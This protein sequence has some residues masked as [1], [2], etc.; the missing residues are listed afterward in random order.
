MWSEGARSAMR[1]AAHP[2]D[3]ISTPVYCRRRPRYDDDRST[4]SSSRPVILQAS[5]L[6]AARAQMRWRAAT[7]RS[8]RTSAGI[9]MTIS[10]PPG[11]RNPHFYRQPTRKRDSAGLRTVET[12]STIFC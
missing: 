7:Q 5:S 2:D 6:P 9:L 12:D 8:R 4:E 11:E 3:V 1:R 10:A